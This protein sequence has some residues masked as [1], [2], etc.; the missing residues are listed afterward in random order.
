M[1]E[2]TALRAF[3]EFFPLSDIAKAH[4]TATEGF[5]ALRTRHLL[6]LV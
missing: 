3:G 2:L 4:Y 5:T 6:L 1:G